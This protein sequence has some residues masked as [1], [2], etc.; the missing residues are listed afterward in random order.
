MLHSLERVSE[1]I[2]VEVEQAIEHPVLRVE[3]V[4]VCIASIAYAGNH[5][6]GAGIQ[7]VSRCWSQPAIS[8]H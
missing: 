3:E 5:T 2:V 6:I 8:I 1:I 7:A 4:V